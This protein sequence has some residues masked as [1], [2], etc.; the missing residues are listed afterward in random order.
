M[1]SQPSYTL[2]S[3]EA[4]LWSRKSIKTEAKFLDQLLCARYCSKYF[5]H[6]FSDNPFNPHNKPEKNVLLSPFLQMSAPV[7][8]F[9]LCHWES[10]H[11]LQLL[12][13][14]RNQHLLNVTASICLTPALPILFW[15]PTGWDSI[16][17]GIRHIHALDLQLL[18]ERMLGEKAELTRKMSLSSF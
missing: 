1:N 4:V 3:G 2:Q 16:Y 17:L 6:G 18:K 13:A 12:Q 9:P 14:L 8:T 11:E 15:T 7:L 5:I 10:L